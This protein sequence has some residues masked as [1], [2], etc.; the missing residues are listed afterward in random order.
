MFQRGIT[1]ANH[2]L[3]FRFHK[4]YLLIVILDDARLNDKNNKIFKRSNLM[5]SKK[6][7]NPSVLA[8]L[9]NNIGLW[10]LG[11]SQVNDQSI[12]FDTVTDLTI[13]QPAIPLKQDQGTTNMITELLS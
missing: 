5:D 11:V 7:A 12:R 3:R 8:N 13:I 9:N 4:T 1:Q 6:L 2:Y 10:Y